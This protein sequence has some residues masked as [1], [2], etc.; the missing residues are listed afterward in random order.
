VLVASFI[1]WTARARST[2][3]VKKERSWTRCIDVSCSPGML[4]NVIM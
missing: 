1:S 4:L 2:Q 3:W